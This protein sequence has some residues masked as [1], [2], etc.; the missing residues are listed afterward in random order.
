[1]LV[2]QR[3]EP[4]KGDGLV[5]GIETGHEDFAQEKSKKT[6]KKK[7][8]RHDEERIHVVRKGES[9]WLIALKELG[10]G[11]RYHELMK[12]NGLDTVD[13]VEG[14]IIILPKGERHG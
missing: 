5:K 9:L 14:Q 6:Q 8:T 13:V 2:F 11:T 3:G 12:L 4:Q 1:M 10:R 7:E